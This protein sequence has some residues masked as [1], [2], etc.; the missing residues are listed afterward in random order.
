ML[1][2]RPAMSTDTFL[3]IIIAL[4][5]TVLVAVG[6]YLILVL[7]ETRVSLRTFNRVLSRVDSVLGVVENKLVRPAS[8]VFSGLGI[9]KELVD[10]FYDFKRKKEPRDGG[11]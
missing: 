2:S 6:I 9:V 3:L 10:L 1:L 5:A 8:S 11:E 7:N 4:V